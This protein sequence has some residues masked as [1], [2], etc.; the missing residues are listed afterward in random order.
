MTPETKARRSVTIDQV[1]TD[2]ALSYRFDASAQ[3]RTTMGWLEWVYL[4]IAIP[5]VVVLALIMAPMQVADKSAH[6]LRADQISRG[7]LFAS[8]G[9]DVDSGLA[10]FAH[11]F[12]GIH[13]HTEAKV[14]AELAAQAGELRFDD[15]VRTENFQNT[16]QYGPALY[17]PD[18]VALL[19]ARGMHLSVACG[20]LLAQIVNGL[21]AIGLSLLALRILR[22]GR[23]LALSVLLLPMSLSTFGSVSQDAQIIALTFLAIALVSR[24]AA[25]IRALDRGELAIFLIIVVI[26]TMA[27]PS[28]FALLA[29]L[30]ANKGWRTNAVPLVWGVGGA[31][32]AICLWFVLLRVWLM[33]PTPADWSVH[34]QFIGIITH[35]LRLPMAMLATFEANSYDL[36]ASIV[37]RLGWYDTPLPVWTCRAGL[38]VLAAAFLLGSN[39]PPYWRPALAAAVTAMLLLVAIAAALYL[40]WTPVGK[41]TIDGVQGRYFLPLLPLVGWLMPRLPRWPSLVIR[42]LWIIVLLLPLVSVPVAVATIADRYYGGF[43]DMLEA[44]KLLSK[45]APDPLGLVSQGGVFP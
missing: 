41:A 24:A 5:S 11:L 27:R 32:V 10:A 25:E 20:L 23:A 33:P 18:A 44:V 45:H 34:D 12:E 26:A 13:F 8:I 21:V 22:H 43:G 35:P 38:L 19:V 31:V 2:T 4:A 14:T 36:P 37:G 15:L 28:S 40:S 30:A 6:S 16:A 39:P 29:L 1:I 7:T 3:P 9:G 17:A 42:R